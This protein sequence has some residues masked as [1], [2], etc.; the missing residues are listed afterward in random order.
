MASREEKFGQLVML[1]AMLDR[2]DALTKS[3]T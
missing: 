3:E 2:M 1:H